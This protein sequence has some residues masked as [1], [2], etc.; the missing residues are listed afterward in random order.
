M[1][2]KLEYP[3]NKYEAGINE[4]FRPLGQALWLKIGQF[5]TTQTPLF[6]PK[7]RTMPFYIKSTLSCATATTRTLLYGLLLIARPGVALRCQVC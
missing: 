1:G 2:Q 6:F 3:N 7:R 5:W 4:V